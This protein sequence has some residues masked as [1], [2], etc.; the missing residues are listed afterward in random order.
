[1]CTQV[2]GIY[3]LSYPFYFYDIGLHIY[4]VGGSSVLN[5]IILLYRGFPKCGHRDHPAREPDSGLSLLF[6]IYFRTKY[7]N[8]GIQE[9]RINVTN[10]APANA[11][12]VH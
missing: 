12:D 6:T 1:M 9:L 8:E 7:K 10:E 4:G 2:P 5:V 3:L 11:P